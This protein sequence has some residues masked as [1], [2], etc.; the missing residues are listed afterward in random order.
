MRYYALHALQNCFLHDDGVVMHQ[1]RF[2]VAIPVVVSQCTFMPD[3]ING[4][5]V[6]REQMDVVVADCIVQLA[7]LMGDDSLWKPMNHKLLMHTRNERAHTRF[8]ALKSIKKMVERLQEE[9]LIFLPETLPFLAELLEDSHSKVENTSKEIIRL[10]E[11]VS[12]E[13]LEQ[14]LKGG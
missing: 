14:Y 1:Q 12:G 8:L 2:E 9:Y 10:L 11:Q 5:E 7:V 6:S 13:D 4:S 3:S